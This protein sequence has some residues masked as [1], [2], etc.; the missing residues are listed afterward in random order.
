MRFFYVTI[1]L[2]PHSNAMMLVFISILWLKKLSHSYSNESW[3]EGVGAWS[4][5]NVCLTSK[6]VLNDFTA[7]LP[8]RSGKHYLDR[9]KVMQEDVEVRSMQNVWGSAESPHSFS[10]R[11]T[12]LSWIW[13]FNRDWGQMWGFWGLAGSTWIL[14]KVQWVV[15]NRHG[16]PT[17]CLS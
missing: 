14:T 12:G 6:T 15:F 9:G 8:S 5:D 2:C 7:L 17:V 16:W 10:V 11:C 1:L 4:W 3:L 13:R